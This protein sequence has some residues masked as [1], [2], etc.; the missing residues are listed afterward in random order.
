MTTPAHHP[1]EITLYLDDT[2]A[3]A[4]L[5]TAIENTKAPYRTVFA[6]PNTT[7][8]RPRAIPAL[9]TQY[10]IIEGAENL[11]RYFGV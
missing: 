11:K 4:A 9:E 8:G 1:L 10:G 3:S 7:G 5:R 6:V 2:P